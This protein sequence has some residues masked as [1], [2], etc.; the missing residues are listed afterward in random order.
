MSYTVSTI[1]ACTREEI[2]ELDALLVEL[3]GS[4]E[5][6]HTPLCLVV[7]QRVLAAGHVLA[8][9]REEH[10]QKII[11]MGTLYVFPTLSGDTGVIKS[12][13]VTRVCRRQGLGRR[14]VKFLI[15]EAC[16]LQ[17]NHIDLTSRPSR[18]EAH[19]LYTSLGFVERD[20]KVFRLQM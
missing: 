4:V 16:R 8:V 6:M 1:D 10:T 13:I 20:T 18:E 2:R 14:L 12:V 19:D 15:T 7:V 3:K 9:M 17:L 11:G 5:E